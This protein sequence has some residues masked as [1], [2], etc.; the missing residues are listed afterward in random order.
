MAG[1]LEAQGRLN[2]I[3]P[4]RLLLVHDQHA[5]RRFLVDTGASF[6]IIPHQSPMPP[7][8]PA[9]AGPNGAAIACWGSSLE[10]LTLGKCTYKWSFLLANVHYPILGIDFLSHFNIDVRAGT[11]QLVDARTACVIVT[12]PSLGG[13]P[14]PLAEVFLAS[15]GCVRSDPRAAPPVEATCTRSD[16]RAPP[17]GGA[18]AVSPGSSKAEIVKAPSGSKVSSQGEA[19]EPL[20]F[21]KNVPDD[22]AVLLRGFEAVVNPSGSLPR[23]SMACSISLL[24]PVLRWQPSSGD[25]KSTNSRLHVQS[26]GR[27]K[28]MA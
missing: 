4:G 26:S 16:L 9:L 20:V 18:L 2:A 15:E 22:V 5:G 10:T 7:T 6:S 17:P 3:S 25:W 27:W 13:G 19:A 23:V 21:P 11:R 28:L 12:E 1:K 14:A 24:L 8:G